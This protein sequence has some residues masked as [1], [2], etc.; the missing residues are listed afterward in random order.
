MTVLAAASLG[1]Q[2]MTKA[3]VRGEPRLAAAA[4]KEQAFT[5]A[6]DIA[7]EL[8]LLASGILREIAADALENARGC[9][10]ENRSQFSAKLSELRVV[11]RRDLPT[12]QA[13]NFKELDGAAHAKIGMPAQGAEIKDLP[14]SAG[15]MVKAENPDSSSST[16]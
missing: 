9:K 13:P 5:A 3:G 15:E 10:R 6:G 1:L 16:G 4:E 8:D 12:T 7:A 14:A 2:D 11:M